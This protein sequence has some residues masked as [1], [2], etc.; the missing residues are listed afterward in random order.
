MVKEKLFKMVF[1][2]YVF[3]EWD[4]VKY[5]LILNDVKFL[6]KFVLLIFVIG[7]VFVYLYGGMFIIKVILIYIKVVNFYKFLF[8]C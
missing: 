1:V 8:L 6:I 5:Y 3:L 7:L 4:F 2:L